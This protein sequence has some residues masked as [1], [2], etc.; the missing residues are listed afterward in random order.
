MTDTHWMT[1]DT[2]NRLTE[3][4][5]VL[6]RPLNDVRQ[7]DGGPGAE[8]VQ[9]WDIP[10]PEART[11]RIRRIRGLLH[12]AVVGRT[13]PDDGVAEP[14]M[15]LTVRYAGEEGTDTFLLGVR[16]GADPVDLTVYSADSPIG[17]AI[18][19]AVPGETRTYRAPS[20]AVIRLTLVE[21]APFGKH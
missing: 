21:A 19:G 16:D 4:L 13:P 10:D 14:G 7:P 20:G 17:K 18:T 15:V 8:A 3:E 9:R 12:D 5:A 2:H 11:T 1:Q 6:T